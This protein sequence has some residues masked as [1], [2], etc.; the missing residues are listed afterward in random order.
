[1]DAPDEWGVQG[2]DV[3]ACL[4]RIGLAG[5]HRAAPSPE[6]LRALHRAHAT[7][8]SHE[9]IDVVLGR[10]VT[11]DVPSVQSKLV[12][13]HRGGNCLELNLLFAAVLQRLGFAVTRLAGRV[14]M[15]SDI[16]RSRTHVMLM[17]DL[18]GRTWLADVGF[19]GPGLLDPLPLA[20]GARGIQEG[21]GY[22]LRLTGDRQWVL[23]A[24]RDT[25]D[26]QDPFDL[27]S[28][29]LEPRYAVDYVVAN[30]YITTHPSSPFTGQLIVQRSLPEQ[31]LL[32]RGTTLVRTWPGG[33]E[34][35]EEL[36]AAEV[37]GLLAN[38][39]AV[40][41]DGADARALSALL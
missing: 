39:F 9:N 28:F 22:G 24:D 35:T 1:M 3:D 32:L 29:T 41:L 27:Y 4:R 30:H 7:V 26:V 5:I 21:W 12:D 17:V 23:H 40:V 38:E 11:V 2:L 36:S 15:G 25:A 18:G 19:G 16:P 37:P 13:R 34:Q 14:R 6:L 31:R 10:T 20:D 8:Y 33:K